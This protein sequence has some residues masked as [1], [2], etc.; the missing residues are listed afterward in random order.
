MTTESVI[1]AW[2]E[3]QGW[4]AAEISCYDEEGIEGWRWSHAKYPAEFEETG[5][6]CDPPPISEAMHE[7]WERWA[8]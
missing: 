2:F 6:W 4:T 5:S 3:R 1:R 8:C 7:Y